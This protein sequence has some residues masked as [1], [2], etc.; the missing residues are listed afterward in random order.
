MYILQISDLH[1]GKDV[2][3]EKMNCKIECLYEAIS[4]LV[5]HNDQLVCCILGDI[6][7]KGCKDYFSYSYDVINN[8]FSRMRDIV[9]TNNFK[10]VILP[11]N[12]DLCDGKFDDFNSLISHFSDNGVAFSDEESIHISN[13][14]GYKFVIVSSVLMGNHNF[15]QIDYKLLKTLSI[16]E[17]LI[18]LTHHSLINSDENDSAAIR[19]GYEFQKIL[20]DCNSIALLHGHTHGFKRYTVGDGCQIIGVGPMF[21]EEVDISNQCNLVVI[22][23]NYVSSVRTLTYQD[24][25]KIWDVAETYIRPERYSYFGTSPYNLYNQVLQDA[26][27]GCVLTNL[28][29]QLDVGYDYFKKEVYEHFPDSLEEAKKWQDD[30]RPNCLEYTHAELMNYNGKSWLDFICDTLKEKPTSK[31]AIIPLIDKSMAY[32]GGDDRLVSFDVIQFG[33]E[34]DKP[35]ELYVTVYMRALEIRYFLPINICE[36]FIIVERIK[37]RIPQINSVSVCFFA[38]KAEAKG[39]YGCYAKARL[40]LISES[41]ICGLIADG[42][43]DELQE[44]IVE[45]ANMADTI[46]ETEWLE[47]LKNVIKDYGKFEN[48]REI[49]KKIEAVEVSLKKLKTARLHQSDYSM[50]QHL[51]GDFV[52]CMHELSECI[53][54]VND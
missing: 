45:K 53:G 40:D 41:S 25:R 13:Y 21:K 11:G 52:K 6:I 50:T 4:S 47:K 32:Q 51:E 42:R 36:I 19:S 31:R 33:F 30:V 17:K 26:E 22:H 24:D 16:G 23:G 8:L 28:K 37:E 12:H 14:F 9:D 5:N 38:F 39:N 1:I 49:N 54:D 2:D 34:R 10:T 3:Y 7:D 29:I 35:K 27:F 46:I 48:I 15:G 43:I 20:E 44:L 18:F